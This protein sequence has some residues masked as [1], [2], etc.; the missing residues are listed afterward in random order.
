MPHNKDFNVKHAG[1]ICNCQTTECMASAVF[2][3]Q[4][5]PLFIYLCAYFDMQVSRKLL[6]VAGLIKVC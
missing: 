6:F 5:V 1:V 2:A 3:L 4:L